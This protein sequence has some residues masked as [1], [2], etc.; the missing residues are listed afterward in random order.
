MNNLLSEIGVK[1][2]I[3]ANGKMSIIGVSITNQDIMADVNYALSN[4]FEVDDLESKLGRACACELG[5]QD[6]TFVNSAASGIVLA[7]T[8][9]KNKGMP[10]KT[11]N[12]YKGMIKIGVMQGHLINFGGSIQLGLD[13]A[14]AQTCICGFANQSNEAD[15]RNLLE[16]EIDGFLYIKSH[17]CVQKNHLSPEEAYK[18]CQ[19]YGVPMIIDIAAEENTM[20][21]ASICELAILSGSKYYGAPTSGLVL[22]KNEYVNWV[23]KEYLGIGRFMKMGKESIIGLASAILLHPPHGTNKIKLETLEA[24]AT[25]I[26][27]ITGLKSEVKQD[28]AGREIYRINIT[29]NSRNYGRD[30]TSVAEM[31]KNHN[32][33]IYVRD[34]EKNSGVLEL[35]SRGCDINDIKVIV[36]LLEKWSK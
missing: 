14:N 21:Y 29:I 6:G 28:S 34:Y 23:R 11:L 1:Q 35:D 12:N 30:A 4:F 32:P 3:N 19:E 24:I 17:H 5:Y 7:C 27:Q 26:N 33:A 16:T 8:G 9:L 18:L 13:M 2:V 36:K 25:E 15:M 20:K 31:F 10:Q 22:G